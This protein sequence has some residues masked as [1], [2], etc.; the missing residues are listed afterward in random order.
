MLEPIRPAGLRRA[1]AA[2]VALGALLFLAGEVRAAP[3]AE[4]WA[5]WERHDPRSAEDIEHGD[6]SAWLGRHVTPSADGVHRVH[7]GGVTTRDR[8]LLDAYLRRLA[9]VP[10]S[11]YR[12]AAQR[13]YWINF[14]NALTIQVVLDHYPVESI[15]AIDISPG[16][17]SVGPWRKKLVEVEGVALSL[18][19][20]EHR[21]LRP[22]WRDPRLHYALNCAS[23]GC[24]SL[25]RS[26]YTAEDLEAQLDAAARGFVNHPRGVERGSKGLIL[27]SL[28]EWFAADFGG[29]R[30]AV[31]EHLGR[32]AEPEL[33]QHLSRGAEIEGYRYD[34]RLNDTAT[35]P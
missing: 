3:S 19:D 15:R 4:R 17:F 35:A 8:A 6:W 26:A 34:W 2:C 18:D 32:Y 13:P 24:P 10:I 27:S 14:Y 33:A 25:R 9:D 11:S 1:L 23:I 20:I 22:I 30:E 21:I 5:R 16:W 29:D 7:Y 31:I 12:R 28:Y